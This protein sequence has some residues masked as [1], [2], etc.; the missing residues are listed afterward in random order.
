M[1]ALYG[2]VRRATPT[3]SAPS[4]TATRS[5]SAAGGRS[6]S[7][8]RR[9]TPRT[10]SRSTTTSTGAMF[11]GEAIGTYLPWAPPSGRRSRRPRST[12]TRSPTSVAAM[13]ARRPTALL[14][15]HFGPV[16]D[17]DEASTW[18]CDG[19]AVVDGGPRAPR[20]RSRRRRRCPDREVR[21]EL[22]TDELA[23]AGVALDDVLDRY[24]A[25]GSIRMN[26]Q[27]LGRYWRKQRW[28]PRLR[29]AEPVARRRRTPRGR[30][31][32]SSG[33]PPRPPRSPAGAGEDVATHVP[34]PQR[35]GLGDVVAGLRAPEVR[36]RLGVA[37]L[38]GQRRRR[39]DH[40]LGLHL[41]GGRACRAAP[42]RRADRLGGTA[43]PAQAVGD[44]V[45]LV[46]A[47]RSCAGMSSARSPRSAPPFEAVV[48]EAEHLA[49][50]RGPRGQ[51]L[52]LLGLDGRGV[53]VVA[54]Q[55]L[56]RAA[57]SRESTSFARV[58]RVAR[59]TSSTTSRG[60]S[61]TFDGVPCGRPPARGCRDLGM[62]QA[63][64]RETERAAPAGRPVR[65]MSRQRPTLPPGRPGS[66][67]GA[68]GLN[69]RVRDGTGCSPSAMATETGCPHA[70]DGEG[71]ALE[72][73]SR[74]AIAS[75]SMKK[76]QVLGL[77]VRVSSTR[78]R[79][80]TSR[81]STSWSS[82]ALTW[83]PSGKPHLRASFALRCF[84]RLSLPNVANQPC[85]W[86]DNWHTRG[87]SAPVL[88]Y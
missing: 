58:G 9:D 63:S 16:P 8:T 42:R 75:A 61:G 48:G 77:L 18:P 55:E 85:R 19:G 44:H 65:T 10:T 40:R 37:A 33:T 71:A 86:R 14:T 87:S 36:Q 79:A 81:L 5:R 29:T 62:G 41:A 20:P 68:G 12:S 84:Q 28:R 21:R 30:A 13:R 32:R 56:D 22:A 2:D 83:F 39:N 34:E 31:A 53:G 57:Q 67:I 27:G 80:S 24:D 23:A 11:T 72:Q 25:I 88:S 60:R 38:V 15:S 50:A 45:V 6:P 3:G 17:P 70:D 43:H 47:A 35:V 46:D 73:S 7:S 64:V 66:T 76:S 74:T 59:R 69:F 4:P 78:C 82:R 54:L 51:R 49:D 26:A 52:R 1:R